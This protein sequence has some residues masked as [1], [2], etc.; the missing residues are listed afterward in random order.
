MDLRFKRKNKT[1]MIQISGEIDHHT[2]KELRRQTENALLQMG[3]KNIIFCLQEVSF[4][5]SSGIGMMIGRYKQVQ[6]LGGRVAIAYANEKIAEMIL[7]SGLSQLLP[8]FD[9]IEE[10]LFY[11]EGREIDAV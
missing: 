7:L 10:A 2:A 4:M 11:A 9:S 6:A 1:V 5:D 8:I 3:G